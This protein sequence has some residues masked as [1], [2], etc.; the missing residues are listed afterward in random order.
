MKKYNFETTTIFDEM[1][2]DLGI[3]KISDLDIGEEAS[4][5]G[6]EYK[7]LETWEYKDGKMEIYVE[8]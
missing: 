7:Y 8:V 1:I 6:I 4:R 5:Q 3:E 2:K